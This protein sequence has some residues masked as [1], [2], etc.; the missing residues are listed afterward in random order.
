MFIA[1]CATPKP[2][3]IKQ[4]NDEVMTCDELMLA[5]EQATLSEDIAHSE[6]G[7]TDEN[8]LSALF[9]PPAYFVTYGTSIHAHWNASERKEHL[10]RL[11][12]KKDC[13]KPKDELYQA[14][15]SKTL[16]DLETLKA[17][18]LRGDISDDDYILARKQ[19]L[20]KFE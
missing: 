1:S 10:L 11:Y 2:I 15:V 13:S 17:R 3:D 18:Y 4:A 20:I 19:L 5:Y 12:N 9:F 6:K 16:V 7:A 8:I 14:V